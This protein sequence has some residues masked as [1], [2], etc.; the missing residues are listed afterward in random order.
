MYCI[1][2]GKPVSETATECAACGA[3]LQPSR[4][5]GP[6]H[7][8]QE[9]T[10]ISEQENHVAPSPA[11]SPPLPKV[12]PYSGRILGCRYQLGKCIGGGGMGT[13]YRARRLHIGDMVAV[14][15]LRPEVVGDEL[16]RWRFRREAQAAALLHHPNV[17]VIHDFGE[18]PDGTTYIVMELLEGCSLRQILAEQKTISPERTYEII[19][20]ACA[21]VD[22]AH[23]QGIIHR[24]L[25]PDNI[26]LLDSVDS[27]DYI[28]ILDFGI[29][30]LRDQ[31]TE[32]LGFDKTLTTVGTVIGTPHYMSPEQCRGEPADARSDI[33]SLGVVLY[34]M[35]TGVLPFTAKTPTG[36]AIKHATE[37]P[38]PPS[39]VKPELSQAIERVVLRAMAKEPAH[40][41][42][43]ALELAQDLA[44]AVKKKPAQSMAAATI[45][46]ASPLSA[47]TDMP[48]IHQTGK[49]KL[50]FE[51]QPAAPPPSAR[52]A[53]TAMI[54]GTVFCGLVLLAVLGWL[55]SRSDSSP[56]P[57]T[58][59]EAVTAVT[60]EQLTTPPPAPSPV[61]PVPPEG[62]VYIPGGEF[63]LGRNE[64]DEYERPAHLVTVKPFFIDRTEVTNEQY[65]KFV[66]ET[67]YPSPPSWPGRHF[68][69]GKEQF[70][71]T[72][73]TW[74][75]AMA[76]AEWAGKRLP[77]EEEWE[78]AARGT[79]GR[80]YPWGNI[81]QAGLANITDSKEQ[82]RSFTPVGQY[83]QGASPFGV[84]DLSGNAWEWT[85]SDLKPYPGGSPPVPPYPNLKVI[86]G[87]SYLS[88]PQ[89]ATATF[90]RGWPASRRDWTEI[91]TN[92][93]YSAVGFRCAKDIQPY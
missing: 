4:Q 85:A 93:D 73:V 60:P 10:L 14:K 28:K 82:K 62:M 35:L 24:D 27:S 48:A 58:Q 40:R 52:R 63:R 15:V 64:G 83:P 12:G 59:S 23:R 13:I 61:E 32:K 86:R 42:Q 7:Q 80:I 16:L 18:E 38:K 6:S 66:D 36:V 55:I 84:L 17:V 78:F 81:L 69:V 19:R 3:S 41:H 49:H 11:K 9:S 5:T 87:G 89:K 50:S 88:K 51:T 91:P 30:K 76:Y 34:E 90:R 33:Y 22:A 2:C 70:P 46:L 20:Q 68:P 57:T 31:L 47:T 79:D 67:G 54:I 39:A 65:Q 25:K 53:K 29:A 8:V 75:D 74:E 21:A 44:S 1:N 26:F 77:T 56:S 92:I 43:S 45:K 37:V 72:D 71:V